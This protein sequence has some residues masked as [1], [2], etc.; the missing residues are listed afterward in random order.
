MPAKAAWMDVDLG[1]EV[2]LT[3]GIGDVT[4]EIQI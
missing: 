1:E 4:D 3:I 2:T